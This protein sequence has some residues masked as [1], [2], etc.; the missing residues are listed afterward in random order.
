MFTT[1]SVAK[2]F[3]ASYFAVANA[4]MHYLA[5][6]PYFDDGNVDYAFGHTLLNSTA[7]TALNEFG[8]DFYAS[9]KE[10]LGE[11]RGEYVEEGFFLQNNIEKL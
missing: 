10:T 7:G 4:R 2:M 9:Y 8:D 6:I 1:T 11:R 3:L 5:N